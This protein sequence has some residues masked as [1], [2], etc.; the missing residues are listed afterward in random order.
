MKIVYICL[1]CIICALSY[2]VFLVPHQ[3]VPGGVTGIAMILHFL[4]KTP[5]GIVAI[6]LNIPLFII[7][8]R[9]LGL[10]F[11]FKSVIATFATNVLIDFFIYSVKIS[12]PTDNTILGAL[13][14]GLLL[15]VGLGLIFRGE[16]STGGTDIVGQVL[17]RFTNLSIGMWILIVDF[18]VITM[19]GITTSSFELALLGYLAL[20]LSSKVIDLVIEGMDYARAVFVIS[21]AHEKI[22]DAIYDKMRRGATILD[23]YSAFTKKKRPVIMCVIT[24]KETPLFKSLVKSVDE[25]AFVILTDVFEVLGEG[26]R[27][28]I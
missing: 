7:G 23:G 26:F 25:K 21:E 5:V 8:I 20:F 10:S 14:G 15:G 6:M 27:R 22:I 16:A 17:S 4:Y 2:A 9:V 12:S 24:K 18:F 11:G 28:R 3:I 19:A 1:G 13:Y